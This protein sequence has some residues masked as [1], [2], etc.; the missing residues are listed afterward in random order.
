M[1]S[2]TKMLLIVIAALISLSSTALADKP[3]K[4]DNLIFGVAPGKNANNNARHW[5]EFI[6]YLNANSNTKIQLKM[7]ASV[8][9]FEQQ[10]ARGTYDMVFMNPYQYTTFHQSQGYQAFAK[11]KNKKV[12]GIIVVRKDSPIKSLVDLKDQSVGFPR[13]DV[14]GAS[15]LP[16]A[17]L[18]QE[19]IPVKTSYVDTPSSVYRAVYNGK[20]PAG[21]GVMETYDKLS[22]TVNNELRILWTT[23]QYTPNA[24]AVHPR[25]TWSTVDKIRYTLFFMEHDTQGTV[26]L[27]ALHFHGIQAA[28]DKEWDDI[29]AL[30][31]KLIQ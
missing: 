26:I 30:R 15:L 10:L 9:E 3:G 22:P 1:K 8:E 7:A 24:F 19:K 23:K 17:S 11:E 18:Q 28:K 27:N 21:A 20:L 16:R 31:Q 6:N 2:R 14:F 12:K 4:S 5:H 13:E 29:R 25:V